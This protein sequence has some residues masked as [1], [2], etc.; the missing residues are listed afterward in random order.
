MVGRALGANLLD[1]VRAAQQLEPA[2][3]PQGGPVAIM[4]YSEAAPRPP[5]PR[6]CNRN[7]RPS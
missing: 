1:A 5:G 3:L 4:G 2:E 7:T 6:S